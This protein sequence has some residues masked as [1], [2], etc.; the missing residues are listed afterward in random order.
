MFPTGDARPSYRYGLAADGPGTGAGLRVEEG[1]AVVLLILGRCC[2]ITAT[3]NRSPGFKRE[4]VFASIAAVARD[5]RRVAAGLTRSN[6]FQRGHR[7]AAWKACES[8]LSFALDAGLTSSLDTPGGYA[9][10][11]MQPWAA[12]KH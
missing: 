12:E 5:D 11:H 7:D 2:G 3:A 6:A 10:L 9:H 8:F 1:C 4:L